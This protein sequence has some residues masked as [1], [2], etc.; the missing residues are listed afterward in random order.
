MSARH[1]QR[2][3][4]LLALAASGCGDPNGTTAPQ[5]PAR[6]EISAEQRAELARLADPASWELLEAERLDGWPKKLRDPRSGLV[7]A[8]LPAGE[9]SMG[10]STYAAEMPRHLVRL[11]RPFYMSTTELSVGAWKR[12]VELHGGDPAPPIASDDPTL[13]AT[14]LSWHDAQAYAKTYGYALPTE[15]EWEYAC[16][17]GIA[18]ATPWWSEAASLERR[19]WIHAN[20]GE[21]LHPVGT[22]EANEHGLHDLLGNAWEWC[23]DTFMSGYAV[24][25]PA[26]AQ[27]DPLWTQTPPH[28]VLRGGS[29]FTMP[30]AHPTDRTADLP[31]ARSAFYGVRL[32]KRLPPSSIK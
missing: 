8:L 1:L 15:A 6:N 17:G 24:A 27:V 7:F 12:Y 18:G 20:A 29:W 32:V 23:E 4:L 9:F 14:N 2:A 26:V 5:A 3:G 30:P 19:A 21:R 10:S 25:D 13:P 16:A 11:S 28:R 22:R 31:A